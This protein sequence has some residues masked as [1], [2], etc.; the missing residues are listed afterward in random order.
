[1]RNGIFLSTL[2]AFCIA[3]CI[4]YCV[5]LERGK[6]IGYR[7]AA[8]LLRKSM[9]IGSLDALESLRAGHY[10][11]AIDRLEAMNYSAA[12]SMLEQ[13]DAE[14][15]PVINT[16][17]DQLIA[18]RHAH[19]HSPAE[20]YATEKRLDELLGLLGTGATNRLEMRK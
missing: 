4:G 10:T 16:F 17:K 9:F 15:N 7:Q 5:G 6:R 11:N 19:A 1:M 14:L 8:T 2:F 18:Y 12:V 13:P 3:G 20:Q